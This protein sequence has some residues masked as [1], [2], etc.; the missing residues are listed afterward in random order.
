MNASRKCGACQPSDAIAAARRA[1]LDREQGVTRFF[2]RLD[3]RKQ[4]ADSVISPREL[5]D[6]A[7]YAFGRWVESGDPRD[8]QISTTLEARAR[9]IEAR[10]KPAA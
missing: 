7:A 10:T 4:T 3:P 2:Q 1:A 5:R 6:A 8:L 9:E